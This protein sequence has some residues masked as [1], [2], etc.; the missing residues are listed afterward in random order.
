MRQQDAPVVAPV[1]QTLDIMNPIRWLE[2]NPPG[3]NDLTT[4]EREAIAHFSLLWSFFEARALSTR[5][6]SHSILAL[7]HKWASDGRLNTEPFSSSL[8]YLQQRYY[9]NSVPNN[10]LSTPN[11][12][13][14]DCPELV[15]AVLKFRKHKPSR[16]CCST[17]NRRLQAPKQFIPWLKVGLRNSRAITKL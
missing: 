12:R 2:Q 15:H 17:A 7:A 8:K 4:V 11:L 13:P 9:L 6:S 14:N 5:G 1:T 16:L 10:Y 3:F